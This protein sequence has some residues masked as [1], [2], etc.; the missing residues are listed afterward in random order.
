MAE[1]ANLSNESV[2][3]ILNKDSNQF[4]R[5]LRQMNLFSRIFYICFLSSVRKSGNMTHTQ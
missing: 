5:W 2:A 3:Q 1:R 4:R